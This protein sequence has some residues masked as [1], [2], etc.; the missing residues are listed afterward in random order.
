MNW[1]K[2]PGA[3]TAIWV[4]TWWFVVV[5]SL[6][7]LRLSATPWTS[8]HQASL[9]S[10]ISQ[11]L[12]KL[13]SIESVML[14]N[15]L[16]LCR[17]FSFFL[18][19]FP[20]S[21]S[22]PMCQLFASGGQSTGASASCNSPSNEDSGWLLMARQGHFWNCMYGKKTTCISIVVGEAAKN[23]VNNFFLSTFFYS[24]GN[25]THVIGLLSTYEPM[26]T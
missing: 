15:H 12:L 19:S 23:I 7:R 25:S 5:Q 9:S 3:G 21:G 26:D 8:P 4:A 13:T 24:S 1:H 10:T 2:D 18:Q 11:S 22:F 14:S 6:S 20:A 17:P 16:I